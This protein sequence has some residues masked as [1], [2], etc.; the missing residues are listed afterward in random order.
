MQIR[1]GMTNV[2]LTVGP[3][4]T[5]R[6]VAEMMAERSVGSAIVFDPDGIG[7]GILTER[8]VLRAVADGVNPDRARVADHHVD[9]VTVAAPDWTLEQAAET[10]LRG[11]F[12]HLIVIDDAGTEIIGIISMRDIVRMWTA[13]GRQRR[14]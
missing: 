3:D 9:N 10:M 5:L 6:Q 2:V 8:D 13:P 14:D 12:R 1:D 11:G 4:H 7:P